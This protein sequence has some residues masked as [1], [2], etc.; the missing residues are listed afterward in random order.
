MLSSPPRNYLVPFDRS[1]QV[2]KPALPRAPGIASTPQLSVPS[3]RVR[4]EPRSGLWR[5]LLSTRVATLPTNMSDRTRILVRPTAT[6]VDNHAVST[7]AAGLPMESALPIRRF[8][9]WK[10][11]RNYEGRWWSPTTRSHI[12]FES[13][14]ERD[15]LMM[16]D[17]DQQ[18]IAIAAQPFALLWPRNTTG[19]KHHVPDLFLRMSSGDGRVVDVKHAAAVKQAATQFELT[20]RACDEISW[21]YE[22]FT[23]HDPIV[24]SNITW[25]SGY[26]H[27]RF[28]PGDHVGDRIA[29]TFSTPTSLILGVQDAAGGLDLA[30]SRVL[31]HTYHLMWQQQLR[32]DLPTPLRMDTQ[33]WR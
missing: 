6:Q 21:Q 22:V 5:R 17:F 8:Y 30:V 27:D 18:V 31:A 7:D 4:P 12:A 26:R 9:S 11:K 28:A 33:V 2:Q 24:T 14:L 23:D 16:A 13:L 32:I 1:R 25:L 19:A 3:D 15:A 29:E 20:R 10:G